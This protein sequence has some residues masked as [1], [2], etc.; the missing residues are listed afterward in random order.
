MPADSKYIGQSGLVS[1]DFSGDTVGT[2]NTQT[3]EE[4]GTALRGWDNTRTVI[5]DFANNN[6]FLGVPNVTQD[7]LPFIEPFIG[8]YGRVWCLQAP[9]FFAPSLRGLTMRMIERMCKGLSGIGNYELQTTDITYGNNA[10]TYTVPTG[11]KKGNNNFN[12]RFQETQGGIFR[13]IMKYWIT[14]ISD[15]GSGYGTYHGKTW[16]NSLRFS[17]ANH[18]AIMLYALTDNSG[19]AYG[20]DSIEFACMWFGVF[21]TQVP[22]SHFE[23]TQGEHNAMEL[24]L[25]F[26][27]IFHENN[28]IN[29]IA[30]EILVRSNF[31]ADSYNDFDMGPSVF[32][33]YNS[34]MEVE[35]DTDP[36]IAGIEPMQGIVDDAQQATQY[37]SIMGSG[38]GMAPLAESGTEAG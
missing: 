28:S 10:E 26:Y 6:I 5:P 9:I 8:G 37:N 33:A 3:L 22:N 27:G 12:L 30:A 20:L 35:G 24:D 25:P 15:L 23:Y 1:P 32:N 34:R 36:T 17:P 2:I 4:G 13:K 19:G 31:Y 18:S 11:I 16:S 38:T 7:T 29:S 14:G 21:P